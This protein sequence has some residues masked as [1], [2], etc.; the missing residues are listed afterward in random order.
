MKINYIFYIL[1][2]GTLGFFTSCEKSSIFQYEAIKSDM[3]LQFPGG[4][5]GDDFS[6]KMTISKYSH[7]DEELEE[8][9]V[10]DLAIEQVDEMN[11]RIINT[12]EVPYNEELYFDVDATLGEYEYSGSS[13]ALFEPGASTTITFYMEL[14]TNFP[15]HVSIEYPEPGQQFVLGDEISINSYIYDEDGYIESVEFRV[16]D[17]VI[18]TS[19][20]EPYEMIWNSEG[21][22]LG[23]KTIKVVATDDD[24][25]KTT[26]VVEIELVESVNNAPECYIYRPYPNEEFPVGT[27]V[28]IDVEAF[29]YDGSI[30]EVRC[31]VNG[32]LIGNQS[33]EV[34]S[35]EWDTTDYEPSSNFIEAYAVDNNGAEG[36]SSV[37]V[38]LTAAK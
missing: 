26:E 32:Q 8:I 23:N 14:S 1:I 5:S 11:Y 18:G 27:L 28:T 12:I 20:V 25:D 29:D 34:F 17:Q 31:F 16:D 30:E 6:G 21:S 19:T 9:K 36:Y 35:F 33:G 37:T 24:G 10:V 4:K 2:I 22:T 38:V 7:D 15:P 13:H 3:F